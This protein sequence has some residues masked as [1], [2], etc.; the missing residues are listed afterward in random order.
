MSILSQL[1]DGFGFFYGFVKGDFRRIDVRQE[2]YDR[3]G[4]T[5]SDGPGANWGRWH[6]W[7]G[8][9]SVGL[10]ETKAEAEANAIAWMK[11]NPEPV[12]E[13]KPTP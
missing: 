12:R 7:V 11:E 3:P 8:G 13:E 9:E 6:I 5:I 4:S 10:A 2:G 1:P